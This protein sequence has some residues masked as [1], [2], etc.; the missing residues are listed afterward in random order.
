LTNSVDLDFDYCCIEGEE[1]IENA[2][3]TTTYGNNNVESDP[4]YSAEPD[5]HIS[6]GS[7]CKNA[8]SNTYIDP[9]YYDIDGQDRNNGTVDMGADEYW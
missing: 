7:P 9:P 4:S 2:G 1:E 3:G 8:G 5:I 6:S